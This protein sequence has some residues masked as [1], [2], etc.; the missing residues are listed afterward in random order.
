MLCYM[1][2]NKGKENMNIHLIHT[3]TH[4]HT[5]TPSSLN[6]IL[7]V[8]MFCLHACMCSTVC[9]AL[10]EFSTG[11]WVSWNCSCEG[12]ERSTPNHW[13]IC[14]SLQK[15]SFLF[16]G[17][18][19]LFIFQML[20][21]FPVSPPQTLHPIPPPLSLLFASATPASP[22]YHSLMLGH[23]AFAGPRASLP[24]DVR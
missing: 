20:S 17:L 8:W 23:Q 16:F 19:Y 3:H 15:H 18:F 24:I 9:L 2:N 10:R 12:L 7:Y 11:H 14:P 5:H 22:F 6:F 1:E 4:T 21:P 13:A